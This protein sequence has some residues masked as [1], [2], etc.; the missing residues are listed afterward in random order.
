MDVSQHRSPEQSALLTDLYQLTML[1]A[2]YRLDMQQSAV[3]EFFVRRLPD[4][5]NYLIAAGLDSVLDYLENVHFTPDEIAWLESTGRFSKAFL[6]RLA[7]FRFT[8]QVHA[9]REGTIFFASEPVLRVVA[10]LPEAQLVESRIVN[11]LQYQILV[12]SKAARC[13]FAAQRA[14]LIDFG[15]RRAH[16]GE[17]AILGSR[18]SYLAGFDSTAT[19]D[20]G[21][22]FGIPLAG[23]MAHSFIQAHESEIQ[24]FRN[25][26]SCHPDNVILLIDTYDTMLGA[27]RAAQ[28]ARQLRGDGVKIRGVRIDSGDLAAEARRVRAILD[29]EG[30]SDVRIFVS[31]ALD[32]HMIAK[33][34]SQ[35]APVDG[36]CVGTRL[37]VSEDAPS[38]DCA[39]KLQQYAGRLCRKRS[40]WKETWPG[41][42]QVYRQYDPHGLIGR[43]VLCCDDEV[44]EGTPLLKQVMIDG[45]RKSGSPGLQ[46]IRHYCAQQLATLPVQMR[47]LEHVSCSPTKVS[48]RQHALV[49]E[50][51]RAVH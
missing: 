2:Y 5:R 36:F 41:P 14:Q 25:F 3:F 13:R 45:R 31:S 49:A 17:A 1:E 8:G 28:L 32:E 44:D 7:S 35:G 9:M 22:R 12:A 27:K 40:Q 42:R 29:S 37:S 11:L 20:A 10:P 51:D 26:A 50:V 30:G 46:D 33:M 18:A 4:S 38:L 21:R 16:G 24:A 47:T 15:L 48:E 34:V 43:D 39:Y 19:V 6:Q 23:T